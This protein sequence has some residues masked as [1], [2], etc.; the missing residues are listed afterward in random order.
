MK[1]VLAVTLLGASFAFAA[2]PAEKRL[3]AIIIP[4]DKASEQLTLR[5]EGYANEALSEFD[6]LTLKTSDQLFG[7]TPDDDAVA[8]LKRAELGFS[9]SRAAFEGHQ[10]DDAERK[11]RATIKEFGRSVPAMKGCGNLCEAVAMYAASLQARGDVEEAK[12]V[13]LDLLALNPTIELDRKRYQQQFLVLKAQVATSRNAQLRGNVNV[14]SRPAGARVFLNGEFQGFTPMTLQILPIG[15]HL[16]RID[17]PGFR[18][19]GQIVEITPEDQDYD[20]ELVAT[21][22]YKS[23]DNLMDK[24]AGEAL[25][26][27]GGTVMGQVAKS[28]KLDRAIIGVMKETDGQTELTMCYVDLKTGQRFAIKRAA[29]QGDEFGQLKGEVSRMVNSLLNYDN[30]EKITKSSDPLE[31]R[32]G[33]EEWNSDDRGGKNKERDKKKKGGDPLNSVNG[34]ED[35]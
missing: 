7:V 14:K 8:S 5:I 11:L 34:T 26:D 18:Q 23:F 29:F 6:G 35:W 31:N 2:A 4:M 13:L 19:A 15:K 17:R 25:R 21:S 30:A 20:A 1:L 28:M 22:G 3:A 33:M 12:L 32:H 10:Y 9:E 24:L 16:V 27:K